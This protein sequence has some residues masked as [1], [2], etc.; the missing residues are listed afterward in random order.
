MGEGVWCGGGRGVGGGGG[1][2]RASYDSQLLFA[3]GYSTVWQMLSL[4]VSTA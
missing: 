4:T 1:I 2:A 3:I